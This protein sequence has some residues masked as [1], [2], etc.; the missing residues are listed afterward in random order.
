MP[1]C[2]GVTYF[3]IQAIQ[4]AN[5]TNLLDEWPNDALPKGILVTIS[6]AEPLKTLTG[7]M[8]VPEEEKITRVIAIDRTRKISFAI[9]N[10]TI[11]DQNGIPEANSVKDQGKVNDQN[12]AIKA[13]TRNV[14][15]SLGVE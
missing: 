11:P 8:D 12:G 10:I 5:L 6:F 15:G 1:I 13:G 3:K 7:T 9:A 14:P 2:G 4:D